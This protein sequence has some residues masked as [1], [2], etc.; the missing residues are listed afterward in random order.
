[1]TG[2]CVGLGGSARGVADITLYNPTRSPREVGVTVTG[3]EETLVDASLTVPPRATVRL[4]NR[5]VM[6][7]RVSLAVRTGDTETTREWRV[8]G[9]LAATLGTE[10]AFETES[11]RATPR[12]TR[13]D[14]RLDVGVAAGGAD[15]TATVRLDRG[16]ESVFETRRTFPAD[17]RVVYHD[18]VAATGTLAVTATTRTEEVSERVDASGT[19]Q[20]IVHLDGGFVSTVDSTEAG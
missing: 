8:D 20:V 12:G 9:T 19:T 3:T 6:D 7:Q 14:G 15:R 17:T 1:M 11:E 4:H 5:V 13:P 2:G 16:E 10:V 18:R